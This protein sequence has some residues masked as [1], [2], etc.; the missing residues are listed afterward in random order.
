M[1]K[2][3][4]LTK[5]HEENIVLAGKMEFY[6]DELRIL[7]NRLAE[8]AN[9]LVKENDLK[10]LER[11]QN[12]IEIQENN[13]NSIAHAIRTNEKYIDKHYSKKSGEVPPDRTVQHQ[14]EIDSASSFEKNFKELRDS[15]K[16]LS[17]KVS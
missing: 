10:E 7:K 6:K 16:R 12:Q 9:V 3:T 8:I 2:E 15:F 17:A 4:Q 13:A 5:E 14:K 1:E 11:I